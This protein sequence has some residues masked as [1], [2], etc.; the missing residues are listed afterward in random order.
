MDISERDIISIIYRQTYT[1]ISEQ[2]IHCKG[3]YPKVLTH[4]SKQTY[5]VIRRCTTFCRTGY[6]VT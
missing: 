5:S 3:Y 4:T 6:L 2:D 1:D